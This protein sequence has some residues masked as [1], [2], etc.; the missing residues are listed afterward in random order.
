MS[1]PAALSPL[2]EW[3]N[4]IATASAKPLPYIVA[5]LM[6]TVVALTFGS[7]KS[8]LKHLPIL[9]PP[10]GYS[11]TGLE[12]K[13]QF[14]TSA[15]DLLNEARVKFPEQAVRVLTDL[16]D[17]VVLP[18]ELADEVRNEP[19]VDFMS[20]VLEDFHGNVPGFQGIN[21]GAKL[22]D[23]IQHVA[24]KQLTK[25]LA[26]V[27]QPLTSETKLALEINMGNSTEWR[28][29]SIQPILLDIIARLSSR[30]F[31]G[32]ELCRSEDWLRITKTYTVLGFESATRLHLFPRPLRPLVHWFL[33]Y[34]QQLRGL[35]AEARSVVNPVIEKRRRVRQSA[36][37]K[38]QPVPRFDDALDWADEEA[39]GRPYDPAIFQL[40]LSV[41]AIHTTNDL[42]KQV[43]IDL[44]EHPQ[45]VQPIREE[46]VT[47]L[48][49][50]GW[51]K[52]SLYNMKLLDSAIKESQRI[53]PITL[54]SMR[55][56]VE[57]P[58]QLSNG[59][60]LKPGDRFVVD[61]G[62]MWDPKVHQSPEVYDPYRF[63]KMRTQ[64][65]KENQAHLVSTSANHL[66][67]GHGEHACPG[68][69][70]AANEVKIAL[71]HLLM[72]Y[73]WKLAPG[74]PTKPLVSGFS[75]NSNPFAKLM[76]RRR[77]S[78]ELDIDSI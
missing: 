57:K 10:K 41:A 49:E 28:E 6:V 43:V 26:K 75:I 11:I 64:P 30:I 18:P 20:A 29:V 76:I 31:L 56:R 45:F 33:P 71:C 63:L 15:K 51:Q 66:G 9:N 77:E 67:F 24:R 70:F 3:E 23:I 42:L 17:C 39:K 53:K 37:E 14:L 7:S 1:D 4:W 50:G 62:R 36:V 16:G 58:L 78:V 21:A 38:G 27:T 60:T 65:G 74:T 55:R 73:D 61:S 44:A 47:V 59:L 52:T 35:V 19:K 25:Y 22:D 46:I 72:K 8:H 69:F 32:D 48:S 5:F 40:N 13:E 54:T 68:R 34:C 12:T 2:E